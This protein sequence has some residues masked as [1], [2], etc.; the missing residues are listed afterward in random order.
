MVFKPNHK[1]TPRLGKRPL[2]REAVAFRM[3]EG[4]PAR[5]KQI[6]NWQ[7][8]LR[9]YVNLLVMRDGATMKD[10]EV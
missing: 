4:I 2:D 9:N 7:E 1:T 5:L 6:P 10:G 3:A 8:R